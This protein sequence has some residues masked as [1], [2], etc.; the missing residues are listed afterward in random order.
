MSYIVFGLAALS[1]FGLICMLK[2]IKLAIAIIKTATVYI[3]ETPSA[4]FVP[5]IIAIVIAIWW[6]YLILF[7]ILGG[8]SGFWDLYMYIQLEI[9]INQTTVYLD[10]LCIQKLLNIKF[11]ILFSEDYGIMLLYKLYALLY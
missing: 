1:F 4:M 5:P 2:N 9:F 3:V 8:L 7:I 6:I 10:K 11:G